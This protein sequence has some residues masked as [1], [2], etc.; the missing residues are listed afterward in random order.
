MVFELDFKGPNHNIRMHLGNVLLEC[1]LHE[2]FLRSDQFS[3]YKGEEFLS[4]F[5]FKNSA[6][7]VL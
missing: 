2:L 1:D 4:D 5:G 3:V 6:F 7:H